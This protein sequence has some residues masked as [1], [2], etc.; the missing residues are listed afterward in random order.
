MLRYVVFLMDSKSNDH[1]GKVF[2]SIQDVETYIDDAFVDYYCDEVIVAS[3]TDESSRSQ[4][5]NFI[6]RLKAGKNG[7]DKG[8]LR[9]IF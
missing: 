4:N 7:F 6:K 5:L 1:D 2:S 8:Q 9:I 3:F